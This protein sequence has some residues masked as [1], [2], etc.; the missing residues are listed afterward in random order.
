MLLRPR[1]IHRRVSPFYST[2][3]LHARASAPLH[4]SL[5]HPV[6][7]S[8]HGS[9]SHKTYATHAQHG[10]DTQVALPPRP[11]LNLDRGSRRQPDATATPCPNKDVS[12]FSREELEKEL[13]WIQDPLKLANKTKTYL[14]KKNDELEFQKAVALVRH[15]SRKMPCIV[16]WNHLINHRMNQGNVSAALRL[17]NDVFAFT[18]TIGNSAMVRL[19]DGFADEET[20][21]T[22]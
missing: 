19:A 18:P 5:C 10:P 21:S 15:A 3:A 6:T 1:C 22:P 4:V 8:I 16:S 17:Y 7:A 2:L 14:V 9:R 11:D 13:R 20:G 12:P